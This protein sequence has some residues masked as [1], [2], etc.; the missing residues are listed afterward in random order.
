M[1]PTETEAKKPPFS[2]LAVV[3]LVVAFVELVPVLV[4]GPIHRLK[5]EAM[6]EAS[7]AANQ[8]E[9]AEL[10]LWQQENMR[11]YTQ[12]FMEVSK[13]PQLTSAPLAWVPARLTQL[14]QSC[15]VKVESFV[16]T[17]KEG[18]LHPKWLRDMN[19]IL[20]T[21]RLN[22]ARNGDLQHAICLLEEKW[23]SIEVTQLTVLPKWGGP[24]NENTPVHV[25]MTLAVL[26]DTLPV[27]NVYEVSET[28]IDSNSNESFGVPYKKSHSNLSN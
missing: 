7:R 2:L 24:L 10:K 25:T 4:F 27:V 26:A 13:Q 16:E 19:T 11:N 15:D 17:G 6:A 1:K 5:T 18:K 28:S 8:L 20:F 23:P 12:D 9:T 22:C 14:F 3:A 21:L